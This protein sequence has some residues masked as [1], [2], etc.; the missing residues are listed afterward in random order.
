MV[1]IPTLTPDK[2]DDEG[3]AGAQA[4]G[5]SLVLYRAEDNFYA[6]SLMCTHG[7][8]S[9]A[10]GYL[11]GF[12]IECPF[13]QGLFDIRTGEAVG[14][15]CYEPIKTYPVRLNAEGVLE[16]EVPDEDHA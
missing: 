4:G 3:L 2:L 14:A 7:E 16:V 10:D 12:I 6:T 15:P 1:W 13:H 9:L 11:D 5:V 8:A